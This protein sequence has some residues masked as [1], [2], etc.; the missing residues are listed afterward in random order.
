[1]CKYSD[2]QTITL[3]EMP[4]KAPAGQLPR[5][6]DVILH[7]DLVDKLKPGD[8][9]LIY[10]VYKSIGGMSANNSNP[11][12]RTIVIANNVVSLVKAVYQKPISDEDVELIRKVSQRKN[13][14][15][16]L[17]R[18]LAPSIFGNEAIKK[19]VLLLLLGGSEKNLENGTHIRGY[20]LNHLSETSHCY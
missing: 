20:S 17:S 9:A 3:Q 10:G 19:A 11:T 5:S 7:A 15:Q 13:V 16:L 18:S 6:V 8:R 1:M 4:E 14:F 12:F 2:Y